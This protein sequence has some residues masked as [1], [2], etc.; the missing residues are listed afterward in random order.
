MTQTIY[1]NHL[2]HQLI[3]HAFAIKVI[4]GRLREISE[5]LRSSSECVIYFT[6]RNHQRL[7]QLQ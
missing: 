2:M 4:K 1:G 3:L 6:E 5:K 7:S